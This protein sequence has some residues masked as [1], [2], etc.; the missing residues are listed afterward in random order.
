M[1][2]GIVIV[3]RRRYWVSAWIG[4]EINLL[5]IV[6][7]IVKSELLRLVGNGGLKYFIIQLVSRVCILFV[8][9]IG[10]KV[11]AVLQLLPLPLMIKIGLFPFWVW[12]PHVFITSTLLVI[13][14]LSRIQKLAPILL[15]RRRYWV[16]AWIGLWC[17]LFSSLVGGVGALKT[18]NV[19][20]IFAYSSIS[21]TRWIALCTFI[22]IYLWVVYVILYIVVLVLVIVSISRITTRVLILWIGSLSSYNKLTIAIN[23]IRLRGLPP[24]IG[25]IIKIFIFSTL[26]VWCPWNVASITI[27]LPM[28]VYYYFQVILNNITLSKS[29]VVVERYLVP[30]FLTRIL[31]C[32]L[33]VS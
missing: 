26:I 27:P 13:F 6:P 12:V 14:I 19:K 10:V 2:L 8:S 23:I 32:V 31:I 1:H 25:F 30:S 29:L 33:M 3:L 7:L 4:L 17:C 24:F 5:A 28:R 16:S 9:L 18:L 21:H 22:S 15:L 20:K 11:D